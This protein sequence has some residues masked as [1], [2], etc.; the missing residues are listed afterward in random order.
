[1]R[2]GFFRRKKNNKEMALALSSGA[3]R[4][5]AHIGVIDYLIGAGY[6]FQYIAGSSIGSIVGAYLSLYEN[7]DGLKR[8][9]IET[10]W[11]MLLGLIDVNIINLSQGGII[12]GRRIERFL[13]EL[14]KDSTFD[15]CKIPLII[16]A[17]DIKTGKPVEIS[18]GKIWHA[19]R[20]SIGIPGIFTPM[21]YGE[22]LLIDGGVSL[23]LPGSCLLKRGFSNI[24]GINVLSQPPHILAKKREVNIIESL[25]QSLFIMEST[26]SNEQAKLCKVVVSPPVYDFPFY[27]FTRARELIDI[28]RITAEN[29]LSFKN[30]H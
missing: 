19:V 9:A 21:N 8:I 28:G 13:R 12:R 24:W 17:T 1:M 18:T 5:I 14:F 25:L 27:D 30:N 29:C 16:V 6:S 10:D 23:P 2:F 11:R 26:I 20:A 3:A 15:D 22:R 7:V 4:G